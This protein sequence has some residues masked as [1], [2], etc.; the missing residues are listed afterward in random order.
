[1][2]LIAVA[3]VDVRPANC[4]AENVRANCI[5]CAYC[6]AQAQISGDEN[7][8]ILCGYTEEEEEK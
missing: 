2:Q 1:M 7:L 8:R 3:L 4:P 6:I 5:G